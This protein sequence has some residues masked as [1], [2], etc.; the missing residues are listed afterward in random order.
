ML[1]RRYGRERGAACEGRR[2]DAPFPDGIGAFLE[3]DGAYTTLASAV[4]ILVVL[5]LVFSSVTAVWSLSRAGDVQVSADSACSRNDNFHIV[6]NWLILICSYAAA[7][8]YCR[9]DMF[10]I[11]TAQLI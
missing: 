7:G 11:N 10:L 2:S 9:N 1:G 6:S 8:I 3:E 5:T 4:T